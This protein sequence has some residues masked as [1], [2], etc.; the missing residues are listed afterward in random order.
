MCFIFLDKKWEKW[1]FVVLPDEDDDD[2]LLSRY[3]DILEMGKR[4][5]AESRAAAVESK[6]PCR[7]HQVVFT[8]IFNKPSRE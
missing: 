5:R 8:Y 1:C 4:M 7:H 3:A 6:S 2:V